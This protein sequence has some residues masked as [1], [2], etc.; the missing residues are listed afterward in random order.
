MQ[1]QFA[2]RFVYKNTTFDWKLITPASS[3]RGE[4]GKRSVTM[5]AGSLTWLTLIQTNY[6]RILCKFWYFPTGSTI[7]DLGPL[8]AISGYFREYSAAAMHQ[9]MEILVSLGWKY[10]TS[11]TSTSVCNPYKH[12]N[13]EGGIVFF[14]LRTCFLPF[15]ITTAPEK[16]FRVIFPGKQEVFM[17]YIWWPHAQLRVEVSFI[18]HASI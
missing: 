17:W 11:N 5:P 3:S 6:K 13:A 2:F 9:W 8:W 7:P 16:L 14:L 12:T 18:P 10:P 15:W 1:T 4:I